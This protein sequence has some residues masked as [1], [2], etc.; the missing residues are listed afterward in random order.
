M[1]SGRT[2]DLPYNNHRNRNNIQ[3]T[4]SGSNDSGGLNL[5]SSG[6]GSGNSNAINESD[7]RTVYVKNLHENV[8]EELLRELFI[9]VFKFFDIKN[10]QEVCGLHHVVPW[11]LWNGPRD[12]DSHEIL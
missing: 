11:N 8:T 12:R 6:G 7:E 9:Q 10:R 1:Y 5:N 3:L 2:P 4:G